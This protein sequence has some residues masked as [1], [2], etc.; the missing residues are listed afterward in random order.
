[1]KRYFALLLGGIALLQADMGELQKLYEEQRYE[2][3]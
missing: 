3:A 1:M 2:E